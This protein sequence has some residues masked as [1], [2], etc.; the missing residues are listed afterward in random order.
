MYDAAFASTYASP[1]RANGRSTLAA[2]SANSVLTVSE[3][4]AVPGVVPATK[5]PGVS[6]VTNHWAAPFATVTCGS[7]GAAPLA[8]FAL[9]V[10]PDVTRIKVRAAVD[11][12]AR[13]PRQ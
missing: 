4:F 12:A 1:V 8:A 5:P 10:V 7:V 13:N 3:R 11:A 2:P 6:C 9:R